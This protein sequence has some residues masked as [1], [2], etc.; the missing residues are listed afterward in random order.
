MVWAPCLI[1][2]EAIFV[3]VMRF[4]YFQ[5]MLIVFK[6]CVGSYGGGVAIGCVMSGNRILACCKASLISFRKMTF[7]RETQPKL[8][9]AL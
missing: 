9:D 2:R 7:V 1:M 6:T 3:L 4:I 5:D 8:F